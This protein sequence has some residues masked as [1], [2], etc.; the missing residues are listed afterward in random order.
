MTPGAL[1][2]LA[3]VGVVSALWSLFL[4]AQLL[5][6]RAGGTPFCPLEF[7]GG[8]AVAWDSGL[9]DSVH[10]FTGVP[11]AGETAMSLPASKSTRGPVKG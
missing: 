1:A 4:W 10:S 7:R 11:L 9:A 2:W 3:V 6:Y 5:V 8:C